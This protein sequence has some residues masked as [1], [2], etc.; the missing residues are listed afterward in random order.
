MSHN[1]PDKK[2]YTDKN[3]GIASNW[4]GNYV[5]RRTSNTACHGTESEALYRDATSKRRI[6]S[7]RTR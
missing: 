6:L 4:R 7:S 1:D 5:F 2:A 3:T